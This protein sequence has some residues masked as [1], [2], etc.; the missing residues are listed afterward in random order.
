MPGGLAE[1]PRKGE[2]VGNLYTE[3]SE[4]YPKLKVISSQKEDQ[5]WSLSLERFNLEVTRSTHTNNS[6]FHPSSNET[7][8]L[9]IFTLNN[10]IVVR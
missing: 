7:I 6:D 1:I 10:P 8:L 2:D 5:L 3:E 4:F 9:E